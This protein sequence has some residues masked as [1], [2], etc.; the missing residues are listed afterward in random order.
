MVATCSTSQCSSVPW[1]GVTRSRLSTTSGVNVDISKSQLDLSKPWADD[2]GGPKGKN[3]PTRVSDRPILYRLLRFLVSLASLA[4]C[5][6]KK[7]WI[8]LIGRDSDVESS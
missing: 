1:N 6:K 2:F 7:A 4:C 3:R 5:N 8:G